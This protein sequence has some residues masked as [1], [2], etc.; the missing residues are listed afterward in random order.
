[1]TELLLA[2]L[3]LACGIAWAELREWLPLLARKVIAQA[4][5]ALPRETQ[6]R[7]HEEL[8]AEVAIIPGKLSPFVF[9]CS[10]WWGFWRTALIARADTSAS[11]YALRM[12][13]VVLSSLLVVWVAPMLALTL[14]ATA[15][16]SGVLGLRRTP[17]VGRNNVPFILFRFHTRNPRTGA[18]TLCG[19][20][21]R[22][23]ALDW[24]PAL[25]NVVRGEMS[26][27]GPPPSGPRP[28][29]CRL[30]GFKPGLAW[31]RTGSWEDIDEFGKSAFK[32]LQTYFRVLYAE[33]CGNLF[34]PPN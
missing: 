28:A 33:V 1:M 11:R 18:E 8:A 16:G 21:V 6:E 17:C 32:T 2:A 13:D 14:F 15:I 5:A 26:L 3:C 10:V 22:R 25:F 12:T 31:F 34:R 9:A 29:T 23:Y 24:L 19:R 20:Y 4:V 30:L 27:V 7:M